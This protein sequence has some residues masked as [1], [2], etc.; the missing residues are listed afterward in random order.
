MAADVDAKQVEIRPATAE[1]WD[2]LRVI[3]GPKDLDTPS[4]WCLAMRVSQSDPRLKGLKGDRA[5]FAQAQVAVSKEL[6]AAS[7]PPGVLAY[8][9]GE[10]VGW[11][12]VSPRESYARLAK[13]R[14]IPHVDEQP[15]WSV[16]CF[17]VRAGWRR[18]G[19]AGHL[20]EGAVEFARSH[21]A[22]IVEGYPADN[23]GD[24]IDVASAYIGTRA[25]FE[26]HGFTW[27]SDTS[28]VGGGKPR[29]IMR[30]AL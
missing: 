8:V 23:A 2:D 30:R 10:V 6:C 15:V 11:C 29:V 16:V 24:K 26:R 27:A 14:V 4:C 9:D 21:G 1:R 28:S 25:L 12:S 19:L 13:S 5:A 3:L 22:N 17:V 20:L 18:R 7:V